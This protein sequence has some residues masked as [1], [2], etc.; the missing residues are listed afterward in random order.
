M[1]IWGNNSAKNLVKVPYLE[2]TAIKSQFEVKAN[3]ACLINLVRESPREG[4]KWLER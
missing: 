3:K 1:V 2:N 4:N